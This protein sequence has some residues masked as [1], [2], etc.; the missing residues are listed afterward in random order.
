MELIVALVGMVLMM[1]GVLAVN[2]W[3]IY[4]QT[5]EEPETIKFLREMNTEL[6]NRVQAFDAGTFVRL[7]SMS[8]P[9]ETPYV[10]NDDASEAK[11]FT[12]MTGI[13]VNDGEE[14]EAEIRS[15]LEDFGLPF[16]RN[17]RE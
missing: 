6:L 9:W 15:V 11:R 4:R 7:Q 16:D 12:E 17:H 3:L 10:P 13:E 2:L 8:T 1:M 5:R 14:T